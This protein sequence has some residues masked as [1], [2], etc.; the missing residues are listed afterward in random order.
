M[1]GALGS[2]DYWLGTLV[3][4]GRILFWSFVGSVASLAGGIILAVRKQKFTHH[5][6][7]LL[8]SFAA[9]VILST[10]FFDLLAEA[11]E[12]AGNPASVW[13]WVVGGIVWLFLLE[14]SLIW[15]HHHHE[16]HAEHGKTVPWLLTAGD[17]IHNF[18]DGIV[19]A[20]SFLVSPGMGV[21]TSV[22]VAVHEIP[23]EMADFGMLLGRGWSPKKTILVNVASAAVSVIGALLVYW[24]RDWIEPWL[25]QLLAFSGGSFVYLA[26]SDLIPEMHHDHRID[27]WSM[28]V[29]VMCFG[30]GLLIVWGLIRALEG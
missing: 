19:M 11:V 12:L 27:K 15:Y 7:L 4:L 5:Q 30:A 29:Q 13:G 2:S 14:K 6:V 25:P 22:A 24:Q 26:C 18:V 10:A 3:M 17:T 16:E 1:G 20:G 9:G 8:T 21:V 23:H 28:V